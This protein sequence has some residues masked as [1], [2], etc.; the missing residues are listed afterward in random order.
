MSQ[1]MLSVATGT[2]CMGSCPEDNLVS[3]EYAVLVINVYNNVSSTLLYLCTGRHKFLPA[4]SGLLV[5][6]K[7]GY[8]TNQINRNR[9]IFW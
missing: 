9:F 8:F 1:F 4:W 2:Q 3:V 7:D 6:K 5:C